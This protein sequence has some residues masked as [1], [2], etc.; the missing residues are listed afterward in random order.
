MSYSMYAND[1]VLTIGAKALI[2]IESTRVIASSEG[3]QNGCEAPAARHIEA[4][5]DSHTPLITSPGSDRSE[6]LPALSLKVHSPHVYLSITSQVL[7][8]TNYP[9]Q[10]TMVSLRKQPGHHTLTGLSPVRPMSK[11][12]TIGTWKHWGHLNRLQI[13]R[14]FNP[15]IEQPCLYAHTLAVS[16]RHATFVDIV[17]NQRE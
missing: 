13:S 17:Q 15:L 8:A 6:G 1:R 4:L 16:E 3:H 11:P 5:P 12:I 9:I 7:C 14:Y 2:H 10:Y